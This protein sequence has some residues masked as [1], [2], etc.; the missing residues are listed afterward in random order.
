MD[1]PP[2]WMEVRE[3]EVQRIPDFV[4]QPIHE[5][6]TWLGAARA[7]V[8]TAG[9]WIGARQTAPRDLMPEDLMPALRAWA[10]ER[11]NHLDLDLD[12]RQEVWNRPTFR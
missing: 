2:E 7:A 8:V 10:R 3:N 1:L 4:W 12:H 11:E 6:T 5:H 9:R